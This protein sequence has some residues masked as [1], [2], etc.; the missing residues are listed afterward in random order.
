L[1][2]Q[3]QGSFAEITQVVTEQVT[4][5]TFFV[6]QPLETPETDA[7]NRAKAARTLRAIAQRLMAGTLG[8]LLAVSMGIDWQQIS[9]DSALTE[10]SESAEI[11]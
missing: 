1:L 3:S 6:G 11:L 5:T 10:Q 7:L 4:K 2:S 8:L 9:D